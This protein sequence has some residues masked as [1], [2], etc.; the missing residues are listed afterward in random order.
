MKITKSQLRQII[1]EEYSHLVKEVGKNK[2]FQTDS[3]AP[4][5]QLQKIL[6][7]LENENL[8]ENTLRDMVRKLV[9]PLALSLIVATPA[10]YGAN[11]YE[12]YKSAQKP[13]IQKLEQSDADQI[14]EM[15]KAQ[16][17]KTKKLADKQKA[18][19]QKIENQWGAARQAGDLDATRELGEKYRVENH[20][21]NA[22]RAAVFELTAAMKDLQKS[23]T[24]PQKEKGSTHTVF[25]TKVNPIKL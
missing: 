12:A 17:E 5:D 20:K 24:A 8:D 7:D 9:K 1:K 2:S 10:I 19:A 15:L 18:H 23:K 6:K 11:A 13:V 25:S 4:E 22:L 3:K 14:Y 21:S 16:L